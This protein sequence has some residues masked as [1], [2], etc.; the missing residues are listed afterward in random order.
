LLFEREFFYC[1]EKKEDVTDEKER[2]RIIACGVLL[3]LIASERKFIGAGCNEEC[4]IT[5]KKTVQTD[6]KL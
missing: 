3:C 1:N 5:D 6:G 4:Y 2:Y